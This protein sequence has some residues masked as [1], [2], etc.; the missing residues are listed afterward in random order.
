MGTPIK[1]LVVDDDEDDFIILSGLLG[2]INSQQ[3]EAHWAEDGEQALKALESGGFDVCFIDYHLGAH[4]GLELLAEF[5]RR[6][7]VMPTI[8][9]TGQGDYR[10]D[11]QA[12]E[13]GAADFLAKGQLTPTLLER[14]IRY[15]IRNKRAEAELERR[16]QERTAMLQKATEEAEAANRAKSAFLANMSHELRTPMNGILGMAELA[17]MSTSEP[18]VL[19]YIQLLKE[20]AKSLLHI[21]ND[22]LDL[23]KIEAGKAELECAPFRL[24]ALLTAALKPLELTAQVKGLR[25][26]T[27]IGADVPDNLLGDQGRLRQILVNLV[28]NAAK[29]TDSGSI[30]VS[31][32]VAEGGSSLPGVLP[33][34]FQ[35]RDTGLG[36]PESKLGKLF[37][38]FTIGLSSNHPKYGGTGLG[39]AISKKLVEMM[40]GRIWAESSEGEGSVFSFIVAFRLDNS[41][42]LL[43]GKAA[44]H[45]AEGNGK[46]KI[47]LVEDDGVN[48]LMAST[49]LRKKGHEVDTAANGRTAL[50]A[51]A[52]ADY[53][54]VMMDIRMPE[55][56]GEEATRRIRSGKEQ[57]IDPAVPIVALTAYALKGDKERFLMAG[58]N[59]YIAKP[60]DISELDA[61]LNSIR[62][63]RTSN[64]GA[65][66]PE[67][68]R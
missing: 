68:G 67:G 33:L 51:L 64:N 40:D 43:G 30:S 35:V 19:E 52:K 1:V 25:L 20:S 47:L 6:G 8:F 18:G 32:S 24:R 10:V 9:L 5:T 12:M 50:A 62:P 38:S 28:G 23:S 37:E 56:D 27:G 45:G 57:G 22:I 66:P 59:G 26:L 55:M 13:A 42:P 15:S 34:L 3:Y 31:V 16:V 17:L 11:M 58:M 39:L 46:L 65:R 49:L 7:L 60:L 14:S 2:R 61:V 29:F 41:A 21:I 53:D 54:L 63:R 48:R 4:S 36:I 44:S